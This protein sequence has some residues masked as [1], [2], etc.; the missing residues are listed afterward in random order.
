LLLVA[1]NVSR[2]DKGHLVEIDI[3]TYVTG[4]ICFAIGVIAG[5]FLRRKPRASLDAGLGDRDEVNNIGGA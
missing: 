2:H 1:Y 4:T 3:Y 5:A